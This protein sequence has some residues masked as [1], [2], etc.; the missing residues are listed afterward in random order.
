MECGGCLPAWFAESVQLGRPPWSLDPL[1]TR[2]ERYRCPGCG[3]Q[4]RTTF[5]GDAVDFGKSFARHLLTPKSESE[6]AVALAP[7]G[8]AFYPVPFF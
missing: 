1:D 5:H 6:D 8:E 7:I 2:S 4:V 3:G